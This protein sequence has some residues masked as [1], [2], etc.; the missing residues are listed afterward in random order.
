MEYLR[1]LP[2]ERGS[3]LLQSV[4]IQRKRSEDDLL[5]MARMAMDIAQCC[6]G[7]IDCRKTEL[8]KMSGEV[9]GKLLQICEY[10]C[11]GIRVLLL[12][13]RIVADTSN[14]LGEGDRADIIVRLSSFHCEME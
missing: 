5:K 2:C 10:K 6:G 11:L 12:M 1:L 3:C 9:L 14:M 8:R 13:R 7:R 4:I